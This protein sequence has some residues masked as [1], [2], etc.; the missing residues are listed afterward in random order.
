[1][2]DEGLRIPKW[3]VVLVAGAFLSLV[4]YVWTEHVRSYENHCERCEAV[5]RT[6]DTLA[7][8]FKE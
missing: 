6:V 2:P 3:V 7:R 5:S 1:M 4:A 8:E